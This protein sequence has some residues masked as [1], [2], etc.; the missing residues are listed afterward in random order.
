MVPKR[1]KTDS[2]PKLSCFTLLNFQ[3]IRPTRIILHSDL[4]LKNCFLRNIN[5]ETVCG[6]LQ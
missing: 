4:E 1:S 3:M 5:A 6:H 2:D